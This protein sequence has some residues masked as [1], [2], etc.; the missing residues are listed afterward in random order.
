MLTQQKGPGG[1]PAK[2][3][4]FLARLQGF[5]ARAYGI[6]VKGLMGHKSLAMTERYS[7]LSPK[8]LFTPEILDRINQVVVK[9]GH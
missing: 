3:L 1:H 5:E 7:H 8:T 6:V 4:N 2:S 9:S